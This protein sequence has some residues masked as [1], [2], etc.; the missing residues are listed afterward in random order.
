QVVA[1][2]EV[3][4]LARVLER[5]VHALVERDRDAAPAQ[6]LGELAGGGDRLPTARLGDDRDAG[7]G[8][9]LGWAHGALSSGSPSPRSAA[10]R[11]VAAGRRRCASASRLPPMPATGESITPT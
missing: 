10:P 7:R 9:R 11:P 2:L 3:V 6:P 8:A 5:A 1:R 4:D